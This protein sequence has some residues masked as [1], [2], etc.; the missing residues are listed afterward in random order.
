MG[1]RHVVLAAY[2]AAAGCSVPRSRESPAQPAEQ[3]CWGCEDF[4]EQYDVRRQGTI[5]VY[6]AAH[7]KTAVKGIVYNHGHGLELIHALSP[8]EIHTIPETSDDYELRLRPEDKEGTL[9]EIQGP[10]RI[11]YASKGSSTSHVLMRVVDDNGSIHTTIFPRM[12]G[13]VDQQSLDIYER[14][15]QDTLTPQQ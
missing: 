8:M 7:E 9:H 1:L 4:T 2:L 12:S 13:Y 5:E 15:V 14:T 3:P 10:V 11:G 6:C